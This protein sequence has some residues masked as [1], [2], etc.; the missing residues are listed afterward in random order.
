MGGMG[1]AI[2]GAWILFRCVIHRKL[3]TALCTLF[4]R[5]LDIGKPRLHA[6]SCST[7]ACAGDFRISLYPTEGAVQ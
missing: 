7:E 4:A 3:L 1:R 6:D 2:C 5:S